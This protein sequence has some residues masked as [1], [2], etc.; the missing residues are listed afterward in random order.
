LVGLDL[1]RTDLGVDLED[2]DIERAAAEVE[3]RHGLFLLLVQPVGQGGCGGFVDDALD[4][5]AGDL[6]GV[7][8]GLA[9]GVVE[10]GRHGDDRVGDFFA[11]R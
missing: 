10:V 11:P 7:L 5:Q 1:E 2:G 8:G 4:V 9:L 6:T 3:H